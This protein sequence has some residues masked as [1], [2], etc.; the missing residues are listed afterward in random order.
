MLQLIVHEVQLQEV[1]HVLQYLL[2]Q[3]QHQYQWEN[4]KRKER[5][6]TGALMG[7]ERYKSGIEK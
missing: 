4:D 7:T 2:Q 6:R 3:Q 1:S 5:E